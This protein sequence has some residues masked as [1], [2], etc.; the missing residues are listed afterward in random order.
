MRHLLKNASYPGNV[1]LTY[2][3]IASGVTCVG[4]GAKISAKP[5]C[6]C[7]YE[8]LRSPRVFFC[9]PCFQHADQIP[10]AQHCSCKIKALRLQP[11]THSHRFPVACLAPVKMAGKNGNTIIHL[12]FDNTLSTCIVWCLARLAG[13]LPDIVISTWYFSGDSATS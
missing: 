11:K 4:V 9:I 5:A 12:T 13:T 8:C 1:V 10:P 7:S 2:Q 3:A 6:S